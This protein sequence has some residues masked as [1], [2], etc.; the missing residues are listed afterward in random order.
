L[1]AKRVAV[2]AISESVQYTAHTNS[3]NMGLPGPIAGGGFGRN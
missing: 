1:Y 3:G 2:S